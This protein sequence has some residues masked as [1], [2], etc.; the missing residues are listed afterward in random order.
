MPKKVRVF[1]IT[2]LGLLGAWYFIYEVF[3]KPSSY[4]DSLV[5]NSIAVQSGGVLNILGFETEVL[6]FSGEGSLA[7]YVRIVGTDGVVIGAGCD[8]LILL[9][10]F[11]IFIL[12]A[13]G[14]IGHK[15]WFMPLGVLIIH[16]FNVIR[17]SALAWVV[18]AYPSSLEFNHDYTFKII[19]FGVVFFLWVCWIKYFSSPNHC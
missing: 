9:A 4:Y 13:P 14:K 5:I 7:N 3:I 1:L 18:K 2:F 6:N 11:V 15:C 8:G 19:V 17:V 16:S 12:S 10:L